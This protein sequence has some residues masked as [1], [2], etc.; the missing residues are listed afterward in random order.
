MKIQVHVPFDGVTLHELRAAL[1]DAME[2]GAPANARVGRT[3]AI[4]PQLTL[5]W[6]REVRPEPAGST[7]LDN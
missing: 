4:A 3:Q 6:N 1:W 5:T 7:E 2:L